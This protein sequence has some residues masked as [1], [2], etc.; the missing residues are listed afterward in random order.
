[1]TAPA[2]WPSLAFEQI[3]D[4][5]DTLHLWTQVVGKVRLVQTPWVNHAWQVPLYVTARG[6]S[7]SL[8]PHAGGAFDIEFDFQAS[9]L[10]VRG[11]GGAM[12]T[13]ALSAKPVAAF[14]ADVM[15]ALARIG[16]PVTIDTTPSERPDPI[17]FPDDR[18]RR[19][20]DPAI[21][22]DMW[23]ALVSIDEAL[24]LFRSG[25]LGKV[26]PT[27]LFWG[28]FDLAVTRFSGRTA[29]PHPG[30]VP[31]LPDAV[32]REAYSHE[33]SSAGFWFGAGVGFPAFY[34]YAYPAPPG[35]AA[36]A[37]E[38]AAARYHE[39]LGEFILPYDAVRAA[40][41]PQRSLLAFLTTTYAAAADLG[42]WDRT[43][44]ECGLGRPGVPR[45]V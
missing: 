1:V 20:Y 17:P 24:K 39:G 41:D 36:A 10:V 16:R 33:V 42:G 19:T 9:Q 45:P 38:P 23:R 30:G 37:V 22:S 2:G 12:A 8:I 26:S 11:A 13:V 3:K 44:L 25:F 35:F 14:Y 27:H 21:A 7:T 31:H 29:P 15:A 40:A 28:S 34:S 18:A 5:A 4:T 32:A 6:L 43:A